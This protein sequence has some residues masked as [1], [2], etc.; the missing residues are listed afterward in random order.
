MYWSF[1][2]VNRTFSLQ[3]AFFGSG[4][5]GNSTP[6][7]FC[8][9]KA[10]GRVCTQVFA[11]IVD[12]HI[13]IFFIG[14]ILFFLAIFTCS[15]IPY[16]FLAIFIH[17]HLYILKYPLSVQFDQGHVINDTFYLF[18]I[19]SSLHVHILFNQITSSS[20]EL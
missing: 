20:C 19:L 16:F 15:H 17:S 5:S 1:F 10:K 12:I 9:S 4:T 11:C 3:K 14:H 18:C 13:I 7:H 8:R 6:L 2:Y